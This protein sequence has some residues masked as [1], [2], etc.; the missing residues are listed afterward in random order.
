MR[1][2]RALET[3]R[4]SLN[5]FTEGDAPA[6]YAAWAA[7]PAVTRF[8]RWQPHRDAAE[9]AQLLRAWVRDYEAK[10][11]WYNWAIRLRADGALIGAIGAV[12]SEE[13][14]WL[15]PG[16]A[17]SR[18]H[19]GRGYMT[20]ALRAVVDYLFAG[21]GQTV[22]R[23]CHAVENPASGRVMRKVGF[24]PVG[25]GFYHKYDGTAVPC[26]NYLLTKEE[27]YDTRGKT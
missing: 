15:E 11:G 23:C 16:Y 22:L 14:D 6:M 1:G 25:E 17:L 13:G 2:T 26:R 20:E 12:L 21:E 19:W 3:A 8:L 7:D 18:A 10:P 24:R 5:R 27:F 9:T 4:L